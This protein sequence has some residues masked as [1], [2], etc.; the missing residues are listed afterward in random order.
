[1]NER[2]VNF[3]LGEINRNLDNKKSRQEALEEERIQTHER[4]NSKIKE[5]SRTDSIVARMLEQQRL[6]ALRTS[7]GRPERYNPELERDRQNTRQLSQRQYQRE[8]SRS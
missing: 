4:Q 3:L 5:Q 6:M 7:S 2:R 1:M 8:Y